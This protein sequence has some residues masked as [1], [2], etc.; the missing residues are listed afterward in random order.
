MK[1]LR[2]KAI[3]RFNSLGETYEQE[4]VTTTSKDINQEKIKL[5]SMFSDMYNQ[6]L[7][8]SGDGILHSLTVDE[9]SEA[10]YKRESAQEE[11]RLREL[12]KKYANRIL[13]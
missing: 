9:I 6:V 13:H 7:A 5:F 1:Y 4:H 12:E 11:S 10:E 2:M 8:I 3:Y